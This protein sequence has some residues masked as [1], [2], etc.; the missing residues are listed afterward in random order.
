[1]GMSTKRSHIFWNS[2]SFVFR[3]LNCLFRVYSTGQKVMAVFSDQHWQ[4]ILVSPDC[5]TNS[6]LYGLDRAKIV[7]HFCSWSFFCRNATL[8]VT[9]CQNGKLQISL[10]T[11]MTC[12]FHGSVPTKKMIN[13]KNDVLCLLCP[14]HTK[15]SLSDYQVTPKYIVKVFHF[16]R[17]L[18]IFWAV[19]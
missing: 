4:C 16:S 5:P 14:T 3:V 18:L 15:L 12:N 8:K 2:F 13:Y 1:M 6:I 11:L 7:H 9:G 19:L 10:V 17:K